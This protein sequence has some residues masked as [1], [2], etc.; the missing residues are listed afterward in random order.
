MREGLKSV[1]WV[2]L[3]SKLLTA[4]AFAAE[5]QILYLRFHSGDVYCY[6]DFPP[7]LYRDFLGAESKGR[8]FLRE[9][10]NQFR[11]ER[12]ARLAVANMK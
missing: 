7:E 1:H 9:I 8:F 2:P 10:R 5:A 3:E 12:L 11:Y 6:L 4:V